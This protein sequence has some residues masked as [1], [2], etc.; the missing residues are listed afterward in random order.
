MHPA[1]YLK[2][3]GAKRRFRH[4]GGTNLLVFCLRM[5]QAPGPCSTNVRNLYH[6]KLFIRRIMTVVGVPA[7]TIVTHPAAILYHAG[8][9][10]VAT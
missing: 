1:Y 6:A 3:D 8:L 5:S 9:Q 2:V 4:G 7:G 10:H